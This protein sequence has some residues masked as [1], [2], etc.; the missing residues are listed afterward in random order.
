MQSHLSVLYFAA[1]IIIGV[2]VTGVITGI[3]LTSDLQNV[4]LTGCRDPKQKASNWT[5]KNHQNSSMIIQKNHHLFHNVYMHSYFSYAMVDSIDYVAE[6]TSIWGLA[7]LYIEH[8]FVVCRGFNW[9]PMT[10]SDMRYTLMK[11]ME[12]IT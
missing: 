9:V 2:N 10:E 8:Y 4:L 6:K 11:Q 7:F 3:N 12:P 5:G 1:I